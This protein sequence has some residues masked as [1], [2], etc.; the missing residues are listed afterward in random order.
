MEFSK[1]FY[2]IDVVVVNQKWTEE[3]HADTSRRL[4]EYLAL[5]DSLR[6]QG[7]SLE[8]V[9]E[10]LKSR[11]SDK[12][13]KRAQFPKPTATSSGHRRNRRDSAVLTA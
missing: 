4:A 3:D 6:A 12:T 8:E 7:Y 13:Q 9:K 10:R 5:R 2:D 1:E 11:F